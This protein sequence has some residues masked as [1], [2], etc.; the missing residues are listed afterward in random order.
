MHFL[1]RVLPQNLVTSGDCKDVLELLFVLMHAAVPAWGSVADA[2]ATPPLLSNVVDTAKMVQTGPVHE[3]YTH[4]RANFSSRLHGRAYVWLSCHTCSPRKLFRL[5]NRCLS[6]WNL[7]QPGYACAA[8]KKEDRSA[9]ETHSPFLDSRV[10]ASIP[11]RRALKGPPFID[12]ASLQ[13]V[14]CMQ[15]QLWHQS[16]RSTSIKAARGGH[17]NTERQRP[18]C[19]RQQWWPRRWMPCR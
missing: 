12:H 15:V 18:C 5:R 1:H 6:I 10:Y 14:H 4:S 16:S 3:A 9:G 7:G 13:T 2:C 17:L 19:R 11:R 8:A